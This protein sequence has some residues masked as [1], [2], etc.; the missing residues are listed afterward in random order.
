MQ[1]SP[2]QTRRYHHSSGQRWGVLIFILSP[3][4]VVAA[5][6][7]LIYYALKDPT[8]QKQPAVGAGAGHTGMSNQSHK[9][10]PTNSSES[11]SS[12]SGK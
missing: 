11:P 4:A 12:Q 3:L 6:C 2:V 1:T 7:V 5:L 9:A 10:S 8:I